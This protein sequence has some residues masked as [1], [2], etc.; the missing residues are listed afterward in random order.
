[1]KKIF[2]STL[3]VVF[4]VAQSALAH[5]PRTVAKEFSHSMMIDGAGKLTLSYKSLHWNESAYLGMKKDETLRKRVVG[6]LWKN[7]GKFETEFDVVIAGVKVPKGSY[8]FGLWFGADD[9][10]KIVLGA[11]GKDLT[12]DLKTATDGPLVTFLTFDLRSTDAP[13]TFTIEGR[14]GKF[15]SSAEVKVPYLSEHNHPAEKKN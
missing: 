9:D 14:G 11:G 15:R 6:S 4:F 10:F 8:T 13:D 7:I 3:L 1:M 5:D 12:L 2:F